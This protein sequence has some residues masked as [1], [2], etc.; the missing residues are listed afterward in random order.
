MNAKDKKLLKKFEKELE[1]ALHYDFVR[2]SWTELKE[3]AEIYKLVYNEELPAQ[4]LRCSTCKLKAIKKLASDY[5]NTKTAGRP[6][7]NLD[8]NSN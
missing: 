6:K 1:L 3:V 8:S 4:K 2:L 7:S 5:F